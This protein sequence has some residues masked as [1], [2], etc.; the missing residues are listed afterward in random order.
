MEDAIRQKYVDEVD[1]G[2]TA[3]VRQAH[4]N[5]MDR[6]SRQAKEGYHR[7]VAELKKQ[8]VSDFA[9]KITVLL[10]ALNDK[11]RKIEINK[12]KTRLQAD[13][14]SWRESVPTQ[15]TA[16]IVSTYWQDYSGR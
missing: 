4:Y 8:D 10:K 7:K 14:P 1:G 15:D 13:Y 3:E 5:I 12:V 9:E 11:L 2:S 6:F 16:E